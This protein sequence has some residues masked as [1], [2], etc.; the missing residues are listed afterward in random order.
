MIIFAHIT[1]NQ[2]LSY[3][4]ATNITNNEN[5]EDMKV[6]DIKMYISTLSIIKKGQEIECGD[7][8]GG[9]K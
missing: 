2:Y 9:R 3:I 7:F 8:L 6:T 5:I 1:N 4:K